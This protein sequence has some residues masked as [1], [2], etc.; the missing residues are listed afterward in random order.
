MDKIINSLVSNYLADYLEINLEKTKTSLLSGT[1]ELSGVKFK[2]NLFQTL[3]IPYLEL[4]DGF[5][6]KIKA[7]LTL[8]RF[9]LY[10]INLFVEQIY[11]KVRPKDVNKISEEEIL[12]TFEIYKKKKLKE[13]EEL[14]NIKFSYLLEDAQ[15]SDRKAGTYRLIENIVNNLHINIEKVVIIFDDCITSPENPFTFGVTLNKLFIES[16][17]RDFTE[18]KEDDKS[19]PFKYKKLSISSLNIF[20]DKIESKNIIKDEK[21]G[22]ISAYHEIKDEK[23]NKLSDKEKDY[24]KDSLNFYL[25]CET[26]MDEYSKNENSHSYLLR[27]LNLDIKLIINEKSEEN[28]EPQIISMIETSTIS[29]NIT[30]KQIESIKNSL[31]Y[32]SL[33]DLYQQSTIDNYFKSKEKMD[34]ETVRKYLED[35]SLYY[36]T[37]YIEIYKNEKENKIYLENMEKIE[38]NLKIENIKALREM[39]NDIINNIIEVGKIDKEIKDKNHGWLNYF[40]SKKN[41][42]IEKLKKE[43]EKKIEEQKKFKTKIVQ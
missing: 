4:E 16:T 15:K 22:D 23:M 37:K 9:Y 20:L 14:I 26:E 35:Y 43:R 6:G 2:K 17:S 24:L 12:K 29:T 7:K 3:N 10:P 13:F 5:I 33:K 28:K 42:D 32:I 27:E 38:K 19:L 30:N 1:V 11:V 8:P 39:G 25:Y 41:M 36:K 40:K 31:N 21:S 18:I 34:D